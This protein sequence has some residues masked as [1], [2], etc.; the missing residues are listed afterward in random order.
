LI[1]SDQEWLFVTSIFGELLQIVYELVEL[2]ETWV[3]P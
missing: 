3:T 1:D 2:V